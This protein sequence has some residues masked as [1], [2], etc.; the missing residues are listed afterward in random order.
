M[1]LWN[2][3]AELSVGSDRSEKPEPLGCGAGIL[4]KCLFPEVDGGTESSSPRRIYHCNEMEV[5]E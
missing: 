1:L 2:V 3:D 4:N 5:M